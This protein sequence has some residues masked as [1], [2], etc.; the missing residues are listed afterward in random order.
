[1]KIL[2]C[3][4]MEGISGV[5]DWE[6]VEPGHPEYERFRRIMTGDVNAAI[7]GACEAGADEVI[8]ADGHEYGRNL[9]IEEL[10]PRALLNCG[11]PSPLAIVQGVET[12]VDGALFIG[13]HARYGS[14]G[15]LLCHTWSGV[16]RNL[17]LNELLVGETGLSAA[18][19]GHFNVP[20]LMISGD[21]RVCSEATELLSGLETAVVKRSLSRQAA[22]CL[23]LETARQRIYSAARRAVE[24]L[25]AG[26]APAVFRVSTPVK[27]T[28][29][30]MEAE[31]MAHA[32][33][34]AGTKQLD[35]TRV[36]YLAEDMLE[37][38]RVFREY[39]EAGA[40]DD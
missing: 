32:R 10:D 11:S 26:Q 35:E 30:L 14:P 13:Y 5:V 33:K 9:L 1:M 27:V 25:K 38:Y 31:M 8:V 34:V 17:W 4:D 7:R 28:V 29:E 19:C 18:V 16:T 21:D 23:P 37:A 24:G 2:I 15:A 3:C 6:H 39:N 22:A 20:V 36:E 40:E 12:G